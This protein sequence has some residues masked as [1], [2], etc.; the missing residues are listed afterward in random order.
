MSRCGQRAKGDW[1]VASCRLI[2]DNALY[3]FSVSIACAARAEH[4]A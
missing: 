3:L 4:S 2:R 1:C